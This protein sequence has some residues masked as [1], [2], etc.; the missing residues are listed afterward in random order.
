MWSFPIET[1]KYTCRAT[2][3]LSATGDE[4]H[5]RL[6]F[7]SE[8][9]RADSELH[10]KMVFDQGPLRPIHCSL[11]QPEYTNRGQACT[12][13]K[14]FFTRTFDKV[15]LHYL[16]GGRVVY[17]FATAG[18]SSQEKLC[19]AF[20]GNMSNF[21]F[22]QMGIFV[23]TLETVFL[24]LFSSQI[25]YVLF[26]EKTYN[27]PEVFEGKSTSRIRFEVL[28][29][30]IP[31]R[32][33]LM[34]L[35]NDLD[36]QSSADFTGKE[37]HMIQQAIGQSFESYQ[38]WSLCQICFQIASWG[39]KVSRF[40]HS[41]PLPSHF[42]A[43]KPCQCQWKGRMSV[44]LAQGCWIDTFSQEL[45]SLPLGPAK[46]FLVR[47]EV[48]ERERLEDVFHSCKT[49][50]VQRFAQVFSFWRDIPW[51]ICAIGVCLF[52]TLEDDTSTAQFVQASKLF[53]KEILDQWD[54]AEAH[55]KGNQSFHM[56]RFFCDPNFPGNLRA[57]MVYWASSDVDVVTMP[58]QLSQALM[59]YCTALTVMQSLEAT[60]HYLAQKISFGRASLPA[61]TCA[62]LRRRTNPDIY[63][64]SFKVSVNRLIGNLS[65]LVPF[66]WDKRSVPSL[67]F[68]PEYCS[69]SVLLSEW[70]W[71]SLQCFCSCFCVQSSCFQCNM[72]W[73]CKDLIQHVYGFSLDAMYG[74]TTD[75]QT[76]LMAAKSNFQRIS[77]IQDDTLDDKEKALRLDHINTRLVTGQYYTM[78][79]AIE[80]AND[81]AGTNQV[82]FQVVCK[83]PERRSYVQRVCFLGKDASWP[84]YD[85]LRTLYL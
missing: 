80:Q 57:Y 19:S 42:Y 9:V 77:G 1:E 2:D 52:D 67:Q 84:N 43:D 73:Q 70:A 21:G 41:C 68:E 15:V 24:F 48:K 76:K 33:A 56:G 69:G 27:I 35:A 8:R 17:G 83:H 61:S 30:L 12:A 16:F 50:M 38:F 6:F 45:M 46:R 58:H 66:E 54:H 20:Q 55:H 26:S 13:Q 64:T 82:I 3:F 29:W 81:A 62:F 5:A 53:A 74:D 4:H 22:Y 40:F 7:Y 39:V 34:F 75:M 18:W 14:M 10:L 63:T 36:Q 59:R 25:G 78:T 65:K 71:L 49:S 31:R 37:I 47:L 72:Y 44:R 23:P 11:H 85:E 60:H 79:K 28:N 32:E 51:R